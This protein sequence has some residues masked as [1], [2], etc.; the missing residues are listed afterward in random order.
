MTDESSLATSDDQLA[1]HR[2]LAADLFNGTWTLIDKPD[3]T[4]DE[5]A[6]M[7]H[8]AHA[9]AY[10]W[11]Q[12]GTAENF[13]RSHWLCSRVYCVVGR[14]EPALYH[15]RLVRDICERNGIGDWDLAFA[16]EA[17]SRAHAVAGNHAESMHWLEQARDASAAI[18]ED[19][20][21][22]LL[23]SDLATIPV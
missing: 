12:V 15:A 21:R 10:H 23:L 18:A 2:K 7:V 3:R 1:M 19:S 9:S 6:L 16:Y 11:L 8:Q 22:Q 17:L 4:P 13:A 14:G 5:E 20:D